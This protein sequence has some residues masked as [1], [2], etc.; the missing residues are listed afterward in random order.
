MH[1]GVGSR[2]MYRLIPAT[3]GLLFTISELFESIRIMCEAAGKR[4]EQIR[5]G[6]GARRL[7]I[8]VTACE[9]RIDQRDGG[10]EP[11]KSVS[12]PPPLGRLS[13]GFRKSSKAEPVGHCR[14]MHINITHIIM[15]ITHVNNEAERACNKRGRAEAPPA[16]PTPRLTPPSTQQPPWH[17]RCRD[18]AR[19]R[20]RRRQRLPIP[21]S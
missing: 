19:F 18:R 1:S 21:P 5:A 4:M 3:G 6:G 12:T 9:F 16:P 11:P 17:P 2:R 20:W 15:F 8:G 13:R 7:R 14:A 10:R